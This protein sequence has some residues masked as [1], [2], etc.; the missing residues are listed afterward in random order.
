M[1]YIIDIVG[2]CNLA[3]P[4]CPVGNFR[5]PDFLGKTR[6]KGIM[7][8]PL[9][10]KVIAKIKRESQ[11]QRPQ[12]LLYNWGEAFLHPR[13]AEF[14]RHVQENSLPVILSSNFSNVFDIKKV[15]RLRP[16]YLRVSLSG[17]TQDTYQKGHKNGDIKLVKSNI[18][19]LKHY[20][21]RLDSHFPVELYYH[22]YKDNLTSDFFGILKLAQELEIGLKLVGA[23][24]A[25]IEKLLSYLSGSTQSDEEKLILNRYLISPERR[26]EIASNYTL[27]DCVFRTNQTVINHDGSVALCCGVYDPTYNISES[28]LEIDFADLQSLKYANSFC[29]ECMGKSLH[30]LGTT[31]PNAEMDRE[32]NMELNKLGFPYKIK[33][34]SLNWLAE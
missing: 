22:L 34:D 15:V 29:S 11:E 2:T 16:D 7:D 32:L 8:F 20:M 24:H 18:Y 17:F 13:L 5:K 28:F 1:Q 21:D 33:V 9:F 4:S 25:P 23:S 10:E 19:L 30:I 6:P 12:I 26:T 31:L 27:S 3:C 14:V